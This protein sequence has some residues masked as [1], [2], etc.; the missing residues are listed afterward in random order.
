VQ[1]FYKFY[2]CGGSQEKKGNN[3]AQEKKRK[4]QRD[5]GET[6]ASTQR[7]K[8]NSDVKPLTRKKSFKQKKSGRGAVARN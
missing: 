3:G 6:M 1:L 4:V 2:Q 7:E 8:E 5:Q